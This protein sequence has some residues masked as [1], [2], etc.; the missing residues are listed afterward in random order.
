[1]KRWVITGMVAAALAVP[2]V[3]PCAEQNAM[4]PQMAVPIGIARH[5]TGPPPPASLVSLR[6]WL[7]S[8]AAA[9]CGVIVAANDGTIVILTAAHDL[10]MRRLSVTTVDGERLRVE[11]TEP[12][13]GHDLALVTATRP[14]LHFEVARIAADPENGAQLSVWGPIEDEPFTYHQAVVRPVDARASAVPPGAF[15]VD[16]PDC[17]HG[18]SGTGVFNAR[19]ELVGI[20]VAG[21]NAGRRRVFVLAE[22]WLP[23][24][25]LAT[26]ALAP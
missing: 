18:D 5:R 15:A 4:P 21:Y 17:D 24:A 13:A 1:M 20:V 8:R 10:T 7:G 12:I 16:C 22:R 23:D 6:G 25:T 11:R 26:T 9:G 14:R 19:E 2:A 3:A